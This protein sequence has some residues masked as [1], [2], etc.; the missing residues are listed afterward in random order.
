[1]LIKLF[2]A[3]VKITAWPVQFFCFRTKVYYEDKRSQSRI[4]KGRAVIISYHTSVF[5]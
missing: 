3:F 2:N 5:D 4:V 1:M